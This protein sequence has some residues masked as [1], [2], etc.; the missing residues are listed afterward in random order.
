MEIDPGLLMKIE[1]EA[2]NLEGLEG[3]STRLKEKLFQMKELKEKIDK[4]KENSGFQ[5]IIDLYLKVHESELKLKKAKEFEI[6]HLTI[7]TIPKILESNEYQAYEM[8]RKIETSSFLLETV[9]RQTYE[10]LAPYKLTL[11]HIFTDNLNKLIPQLSWPFTS[12]GEIIALDTNLLEK[13]KKTI[14]YL[15]ELSTIDHPCTILNKSIVNTISSHFLT[16]SETNLIEKPEWMLN[17]VKNLIRLNILYLLERFEIGHVAL[18]RALQLMVSDIIKI[19]VKRLQFDIKSA[20]ESNMESLFLHIIDSVLGFDKF[21]WEIKSS[22]YLL[23]HFLNEKFVQMWVG[24]EKLYITA[25]IQKILDQESWTLEKIQ[26][27]KYSNLDELILLHQSLMIKYSV[28]L[29]HLV[30]ENLVNSMNKTL[31]FLYIEESGRKFE[32]IKANFFFY[33]SNP[34]FWTQLCQELSVLHQTLLLFQQFLIKTDNQSF[35][36]A[37]ASLNQLKKEVISRTLKLF[38]DNIDDVVQ[39]YIKKCEN[40]AK[41]ETKIVK[42]II[43]DFKSV[44]SPELVRIIMLFTSQNYTEVWLAKLRNKKVSEGNKA[45]VVCEFKNF[46]E[47]F[48]C[49]PEVFENFCAKLR[50]KQ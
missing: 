34:A 43:K 15:S 10:A 24:Y 41:I 30:Q 42:S 8:I 23:S 47:I 44:A 49:D 27:L 20:I 18:D 7:P 45:Q 11:N 48:Y 13:F 46:F 32:G 37:H 14:K 28:I 36:E 39:E 19:V 5:R 3:V 1:D 29:D 12:K 38:G 33:Q 40:N 50:F 35:A 21:L 4:L 26:G 17:F 9:K 16:N 2:G 22:E 6:L 25:E 31:I